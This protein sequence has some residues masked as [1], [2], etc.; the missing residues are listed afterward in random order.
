[1]GKITMKLQVT[2]NAINKLHDIIREE[3]DDALRLRIFVQGGGCSGFQYGFTLDNEQGE[4]DFEI[5]AGSLSVLVDSMSMQYLMDAEIDYSSDI[6]GSSFKIK[7]PNA[8]TTC[9]CGSSFNPF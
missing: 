9:G 4:D 8:Q 1:M 6:N 7:N 2:E 5:P 3:N